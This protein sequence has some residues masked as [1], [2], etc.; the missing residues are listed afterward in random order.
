MLEFKLLEASAPQNWVIEPPLACLPLYLQLSS[1]SYSVH[2]QT[3][4]IE[5]SHNCAESQKP[6][7]V[8]VKKS[9]VAVQVK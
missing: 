8:R 3:R 2:H 7:R 6:D 9:V 1:L 4:A 5:Q